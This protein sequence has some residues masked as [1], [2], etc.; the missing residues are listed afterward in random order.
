MFV[1]RCTNRWRGFRFDDPALPLP[2]P[3]PTSA[4]HN[5]YDNDN[6]D[7]DMTH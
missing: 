7:D 3:L 2:H 1:L 5:D 4:T 6:A